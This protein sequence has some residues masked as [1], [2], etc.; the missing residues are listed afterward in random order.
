LTGRA[1]RSVTDAE[2]RAVTLDALK[3]KAMIFNGC[4]D[5][6]LRQRYGADNIKFVLGDGWYVAEPVTDWVVL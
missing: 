6:W 1:W 5:A 2:I 3:R 4:T